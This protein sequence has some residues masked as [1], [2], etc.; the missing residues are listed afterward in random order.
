MGGVQLFPTTPRTTPPLII[1]SVLRR[2]KTEDALMTAP[3]TENSDE[4]FV[5][6]P[7]YRGGGRVAAVTDSSR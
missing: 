7:Y 1:I 3:E 4:I 5:W 2:S 6:L